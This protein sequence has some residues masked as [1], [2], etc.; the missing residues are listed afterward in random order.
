MKQLNKNTSSG[1][2]WILRKRNDQL[3]WLLK[4]SYNLS[5]TTSSMLAT[6][7]D[8]V[9]E[10]NF[11]SFLDPKVKNLMPDP[12]LLK[13]MDVGVDYAI[14][15]VKNNHKIV[16]FADYD[17]DGGTSAALMSRFF[18]LIG[19]CA[20]IYVPDRVI[21]GYG[22][23]SNAMIRLRENGADLVIT[24]DCGTVAFEPL[25]KAAEIGLK[26]IVIDHHLGVKE[27][28]E[29]IAVINPNRFDEVTDLG[30]LCGVG[31]S[32]MF[33]ASMCIK[34]E[35]LGLI[36][37]KV[38]AKLMNL[39]DLV[40]LGTVCD[41]VPLIGLNR[42]LVSSGLRV[43]TNRSNLG[44]SSLAGLATIPSSEE[45]NVTHLG[46]RIGPMI[47]AGGRI[48]KSDMGANLLASDDH[49]YVST[50]ANELYKLN[51][52]RM[53]IET[54]IIEEAVKKIES[55]DHESESFIF[56]YDQLWHEGVIGIVAS[57][58]KDKYYKPA[59]I[60]SLIEHDGKKMVKASCR[61]ISGVNIGKVIIEA[62]SKKIL[63][64]GGGHGAAAGL[65]VELDKITE[66]ISFVNEKISEDIGIARVNR[67]ME[68]DYHLSLNGVNADLCIDISK[69]EPFGVGNPKPVF[70][71]TD[72]KILSIKVLKEKHISLFLKCES[73]GFT[74]KAICFRC[75]GTRLGDDILKSSGKMVDILC[76]IG[77][78]FYLGELKTEIIIEDIAY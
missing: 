47:N 33:C 37:S 36:D 27:K 23:N 73:S 45:I 18:R 39:I 14:H 26:V 52:E 43:A 6:R 3:Y 40:A 76:S 66:F 15:A 50:A 21:E 17:V 74:H 78:S 53:Q 4:N 9:N 16:I 67:A 31:V 70:V 59:I 19:S 49:D 29:S 71:I 61:S 75:I 1:A 5:D 62:V 30:Y 64:K 41:M 25:A 10:N 54:V 51:K 65:T 8:F 7:G 56:A 32:F 69:L 60:G 20:D 28:P 68:Y 72:L 11:D 2:K 34:M 13:D 77:N 63:L 46:F 35:K 38:K 42:A 48:G 57:R 22:P 12:F 55:S 44:M 58:I 24:V